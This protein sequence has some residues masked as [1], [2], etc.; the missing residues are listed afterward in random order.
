MADKKLDINLDRELQ[1]LEEELEE[2]ARIYTQIKDHYDRI[3]NSK[4]TGALKFVTDQTGNVLKVRSDRIGIV[5]E[6]IGVKK[7]KAEM[8]LKEMNLNKDEN[9]S[10]G[11]INKVAKEIYS[12]MKSDSRAGNIVNLLN[13]GG[14]DEQEPTTEVKE[15]QV[16][17]ENALEERMREIQAKKDKERK[18]KEIKE[19]GYIFACDLNKN[20]YAIDETGA[21]IVEGVDIP[22]F[23]IEFEVNELTGLTIARNQYGD[24][25]EI[26]E[27]SEVEL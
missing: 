9:G 21:G 2:N 12:M 3:M 5:K 13:K 26:V 11:Q 17:N 16:K 1:L 25:L 8:T 14:E 6:M 18:E 27:I 23:E 22:D 7:L 20:V 10:D 19:R 24:I 4:S 15:Q